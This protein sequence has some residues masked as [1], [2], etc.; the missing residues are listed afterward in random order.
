[1]IHVHMFCRWMIASRYPRVVAI[2]PYAFR[3]HSAKAQTFLP[4]TRIDV[5]IS[6]HRQLL[7]L[8]AERIK[9]NRHDM[10]NLCHSFESARC[11]DCSFSLV[12]SRCDLTKG[13]NTVRYSQT[14]PVNSWR[15]SPSC[16]LMTRTSS[17]ISRETNNNRNNCI[18]YCDTTKGLSP[19]KIT[20]H[21]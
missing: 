3:E 9:P 1:M 13:Q 5:C 20:Q 2:I 4:T 6:G 17:R 14:S 8:P 21:L 10:M 12:P 19:I 7:R 16:K 18:R 15:T 11:R